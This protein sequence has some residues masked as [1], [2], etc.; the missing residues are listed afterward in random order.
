[1]Q[2]IMLATGS[3]LA[4]LFI[5]M[6]FKNA[7]YDGYTQNLNNDDYPLY[8]AYCVGFGMNNIKLF[9]LKGKT[10]STLINQAKLLYEQQYAEYYATLVWA[11]V[12]TWV[13]LVLAVCFLLAGAL[14][15]ALFGFAGIVVAVLFAYYFLNKMKN[16]L[17]ERE[18][19]CTLELPEVV[20]SMAM[21]INSGMVLRDAW[22]KIAYSK[23]GTIYDLMRGACV[24]MENGVSDVDAIQQFG[25]LSGS[26]EI[27]KFCSALIQGMEKGSR[28]LSLFLVGQ[29]SEMWEAKKQRLLQKG[30]AA[31]TKLLVPI[32]LIFGGILLMVICAAISMMMV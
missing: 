29:S 32:L 25:V 22:Q 24:Q 21:L 12:L 2:L 27:K 30:E 23:E 6:L 17:A 7:E 28:D 3:V 19:A 18:E 26:Q 13:H 14:D 16:K 5:M 15:F 11:Q 10:R 9:S 20:S 1:M 8:A 4:L 31:A